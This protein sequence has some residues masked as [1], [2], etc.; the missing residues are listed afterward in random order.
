VLLNKEANR[1][2]SLSSLVTMPYDVFIPK[3]G[4][5]K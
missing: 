1:T 3:D 2:L 4:Q 5:L